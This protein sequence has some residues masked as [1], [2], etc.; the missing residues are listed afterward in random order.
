MD[1]ILITGATG[2]IG[3]AVVRCLAEQNAKLCLSGRN[4]TKLKDLISSLPS[5]GHYVLPLNLENPESLEGPLKDAVKSNG[6]FTG[7]VH[8]AGVG[9]VRP[10]RLTK[11]D[12]VNRVMN[13]NFMSYLEIVRVL[14]SKQ[15]KGEYLNI[16]GVSAIG[17]LIGNSTKTAYCASKAAMNAATRCLAKELAP[18]NI[19]INT[20]APGATQTDMMSDILNLPG[21]DKAL[22]K[23][24]ERQFLG[25]C[26]PEDIAQGVSFLLNSQSRMISGHCLP[27][28][29]GKLIN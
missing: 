1:H 22:A 27:V 13:I 20:V 26:E 24:T 4:E 10:V 2:G 9:E 3:Q 14:S 21:G 16:V 11:T 25:I 23:I 28:D 15:C 5:E 12:F 8:A 18:K 7:F 19:R 17:A 6:R 29:G